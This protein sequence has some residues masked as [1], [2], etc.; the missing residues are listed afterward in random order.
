MK[1]GLAIV[2]LA[3]VG[4]V[5]FAASK[6]GAF[7][8][9]L[10]AG[11]DAGPTPPDSDDGPVFTVEAN[12]GAVYQVKFVKA[13]ETESGNQT[14]WDVYDIQGKVL[15]Y[16][17][18]EDDINSRVYIMTARAEGDESGRGRDPAIDIVMR[19]F[20]LDFKG[21]PIGAPE[22]I[23]TGG[24]MPTVG[25]GQ[26]LVSPGH[27]MATAD[28]PFPQSVLVSASLIK[29]ALEEQGWRRV[30]VFT[31]PPRDWPISKQGN[32]FIEGDWDRPARLFSVPSAVVQM[33]SNTLA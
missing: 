11:D 26:T 28:V 4:G 22:V 17:Q 25:P 27:W 24:A 12:S 30:A 23:L 10:G 15:R 7:D 21:G 20:G 14:F 9:L 2:G 19:D 1:A 8:G 31:S 32:Y 13:F 6:A 29:A 5:A 3:V 18:L 16:S 33:K